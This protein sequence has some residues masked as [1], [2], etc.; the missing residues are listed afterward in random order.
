MTVNDDVRYEGE[1]TSQ[2][3]NRLTAY[4][5]ELF[6]GDQP[7]YFSAPLSVTRNLETAQVLIGQ[8]YRLVHK[9]PSTVSR[10]V[11]IVSAELKD[12]EE[13]WALK[14]C[15]DKREIF[16]ELEILWDDIKYL[17]VAIYHY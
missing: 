7:E 15:D 11:D 2:G 12:V 8:G 3:F 14:L 9:S 4:F 5:G 1:R 10:L 6:I 16:Q 13:H 17:C